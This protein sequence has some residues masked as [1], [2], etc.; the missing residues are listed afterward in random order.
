MA[1]I[2]I[3]VFHTGEVCVAPELPFGGEHCSTIKASGVFA[4]K[5][6][7]L[8]LPVSAYLIECDHGKILFDCGWHRDMSPDG[9]FDKGAQVKSLG[10]LP[11]Y[12]TNQGRIE[13]GA[14]IKEQLAALGIHPADLDMV[15]LSHLDCDHANGLK[16]VADAK[17]ILV[18]K[19]ELNFAENG[20]PVNRIRYNADW[21]NG[22]KMQTFD[23]NG[24][25]GPA[26][27]SYDV[28]G[29]GS[30]VMVNIPGHSKG[31]CAL[32]ITGSDGRF[33]L[34]YADGGYARKS[35]EQL[36]TSGI[37]DDKAA[38]K[39]SLQWIREQSM[40]ANCVAS[41]ANHDP[42]VQPHIIEL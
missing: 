37:A 2:K 6:E 28:F 35:W 29:D 25:E 42:D 15:L 33:V 5:S 12:V 30:F 4:K 38:Q 17:Q 19:D 34:L 27:K 11:L 13:K 26:G 9:V 14:A 21:W 36:I 32:K 7:R 40:D 24:T 39:R 31:L 3:H 20:T 8:W 18:S 16:M 22:T 10:S 41:L 23:W 1:K